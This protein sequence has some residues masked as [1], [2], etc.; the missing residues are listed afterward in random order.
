[1]EVPT[2]TGPIIP[3]P[4]I[5]PPPPTPQ[6][7]IAVL[8]NAD[9]MDH[10]AGSLPLGEMKRLTEVSRDLQTAANATNQRRLD[11]LA[12]DPRVQQLALRVRSHLQSPMIRSGF[13]P[14]ADYGTALGGPHTD[15][16]RVTDAVHRFVDVPDAQRRSDMLDWRWTALYTD[17]L[18][19]TRP[20][21]VDRMGR[22]IE[23]GRIVDGVPDGLQGPVEIDRPV[24]E[25]FATVTPARL[26]LPARRRLPTE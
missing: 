19:A 2:N 9:I 8:G 1:M 25:Q 14:G 23:R 13:I 17:D 18:R 22:P 4:T 6:E 24:A 16:E 20:H 15:I 5:A 12:S 26:A 3:L 10:I 11:T 7:T 21:L